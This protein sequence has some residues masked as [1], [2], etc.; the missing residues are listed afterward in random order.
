MKISYN[1]LKEYLDISMDTK[2]VSEILTNIG[3]EVEGEELFES[4]KGGLE[5]FLIGEVITCE[6][7]PN[8][9]KLSI[10][11][12]NVGS[13]ELLK[14]VCGAPN[15]AEGQKV[16]VATVGTTIYMGNDSFKIKRS[17][18]RGEESAG[19]ICAE[20]E[21]GLGAGHEG[22][23]VLDHNAKV[24]M[25]A[26][27]Y[28]RV[29][30]DTIFEIGLTPNRIDA[31]SHYGVARDLAAYISQNQKINLRKPLVN[32]FKIDSTDSKINVSVENNEACHRYSGLSISNIKVDESPE[33]LKTRLLSIGQI[34]INNIVDI[35]NFVLHELG[36]PL[37]AFDA[38][39]ITGNEVIVKTL[40][41][42]TSF[43][44][45]D[46]LE[47]KLSEK[48]L[49]ICNASDGMC[50]AGVFGGA[51][52]GVTGET[53]NIFL[54]SAY[55]NPV[56]VRKTAKHHGLN[57]DSSFRFE[58]GTD[59]NNTVYALKRAA[60]LIKELAGGQINSNI[61]DIYP[62]PVQDFKIKVDFK[63]IDRLIGNSI[64]KENIKH[65]LEALEIRVVN[66]T[67]EGLTVLVPPY[68]VDVQREAD[69]IEEILRIYGYNY[70]TMSNHVN[71][72]ITHYRK[73]DEHKLK[74]LISD[75][76]AAN[77]FNEIMCNS[78]SR[79][80]YYNN[81]SNLPVSNAVKIFN[82]LSQD[83]NVMRQ[84]LLFG[85][86]ETIAYNSNRRNADLKLFEFGNSYRFDKEKETTDPLRK[87]DE[88]EHLSL[89]ICGRKNSNSW[90]NPETRSDFFEIKTFV[91][92]TLKR[93]GYDIRKFEVAEIS[94]E[95][96]SVGLEYKLNQKVLVAFGLVES[97][98]KNRFEIED[99]IYYAE[100]NWNLSFKFLKNHKVSFDELPKYPEVK[101]DLSMIVDKELKFEQLQ[102][103]AY[104]TEKKLLRRINIFDVYSGENI[105]AGK[106]SYAISFF[107]QD[108]TKTLNDKYIDKVMSGLI[109]AF[110]RELNAEI[111]S[112]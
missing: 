24:G 57:T 32:N 58:R 86:L 90:I 49:M 35:T 85:G 62:E 92:L 97:T 65:I 72:T 11:T 16:V 33:W 8:A 112:S 55:F 83:L 110:E 18:I 63:Q 111:R 1:W 87:Y 84:T 34:P 94:N 47:R 7:H 15:V 78:L 95:L 41:D 108:M 82:P 80:A 43:K 66:E 61:I 39:K 45:L 68:R 73:P 76:L 4:V 74:N 14:V 102:K 96:L 59:P 70:V 30:S 5:G 19:M 25:A 54:E 109:K 100:F 28:F 6:K 37:H 46:E 56:S 99:D 67:D 50:I 64:E 52:S 29:E 75:F 10:T 105:P 3:L 17:K 104:K 20:D 93:L 51:D 106:K 81:L 27:D 13:N 44:T 26:K 101:R 77:G 9:K 21:L 98:L 107:L 22:I 40:G 53:R 69:L 12:V 79:E 38:D 2:K 23:M 42:G 36:Q 89:F 48:D 88:R 91:D 60:M 31:A 103:L 71:S